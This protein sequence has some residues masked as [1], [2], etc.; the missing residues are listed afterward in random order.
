M[1][2]HRL[3]G[4]DPMELFE[5][6]R[7]AGDLPH[8]RV[9]DYLFARLSAEVDEVAARVRDLLPPGAPEPVHF[10]H[11]IGGF[12]VTGRLSRLSVQGCVQMRYAGIK[13]KD[14]LA[15][16]LQHLFLCLSAPG[17]PDR[18]SL[19]IGKDQAWA[20]GPVPGAEQI[21]EA[22]LDVYRHGL[23][24]PLPFFPE[25]SRAFFEKL[26]DLDGD[27]PHALAAARSQWLGSDY[28]PGESE[29]PYYRL[30]F[31]ER[32]PLK[33]DFKRLAVAVFQPLFEHGRKIPG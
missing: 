30:C 7:A 3:A 22:L 31:G 24:E 29:N 11:A 4:N 2:Q 1:L 25:S 18:R 28:A 13:A 19:L 8:G 20:F 32:E 21:L 9:G 10:A 26:A 33:D 14:F 12:H 17:V 15:I 23:L 16:W 6:F 27:A 5:V